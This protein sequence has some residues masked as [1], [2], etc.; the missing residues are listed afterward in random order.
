MIEQ[1]K[2]DI[3]EL[4]KDNPRRLNHILGVYKTATKLG[5]LHDLNVEKLQIA[6][7][8]HDITK[9]YT[10]EEN[11]KIIKEN[12]PNYKEILSEF[13]EKI[14]HSFTARVVAQKKYNIKDVDILDS[15]LYHTIGK[16]NMTPYEQVIFLSD[17]IEPNRTYDSCVLVREIAFVDLN[18]ATLKAIEVYIN[19][20]E[21][22]NYKIS[23]QAYHAY[24]YYKME[25]QNG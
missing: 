9:Y 25:V 12:Y 4:F 7:L 1:I 19:Y 21:S 5:E 2:R 24:E 23:T 3:Q 8:L 10:K 22:Q 20:H 18:K 14:L 15:I 16:E 17:Y 11:T 13:D 6:A